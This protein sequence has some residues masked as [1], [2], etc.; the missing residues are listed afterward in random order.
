MGQHKEKSVRNLLEGP[1][2]SGG[3]AVLTDMASYVVWERILDVGCGS[4]FGT[5][6]GSVKAHHVP[7][8]FY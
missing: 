2:A 5:T 6:R 3:L 7:Y 4:H 1:A 8:M